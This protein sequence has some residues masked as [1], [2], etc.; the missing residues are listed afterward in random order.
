[1]KVTGRHVVI[2]GGASGIGAAM[3]RR[4]AADGAAAI[5]VADLD[6]RGAAAVADGLGVP[7]VGIGCDVGDPSAVVGLVDRAEQT[8][9]AVDLFCANAGC[10]GG[11]GLVETTDDEWL[12]AFDVNVLA[13]VV[14]ARR[15]VPGW[16]ERGDGYF[17]STASAAGMLSLVG[18]GAY[19]VTKSAALAFAEWLAISYGARGVKVSCLCPSAVDTPMLAAGLELPGEGGLGMRI[20]T[21]STPV[22]SPEDVADSVAA[23]LDEERFLILPHEQVASMY[24]ARARDLDGWISGMRQVRSAFAGAAPP[25]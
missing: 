7:A 1:M 15:L 17:L 25:A 14:A 6:A 11:N 10:A 12:Q 19:A 23:G 18:G 9:G 20:V 5:V 8:Y 4:F 16:L 21:G 2:T 3:A 24:V 22:L 13:H